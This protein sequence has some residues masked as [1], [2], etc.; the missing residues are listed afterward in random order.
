MRLTI[1]CIVSLSLNSEIRSAETSAVSSAPDNRPVFTVEASGMT[2]NLMPS[3]SGRL[4][5]TMPS[6]LPSLAGET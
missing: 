3:T 2:M 4:E 5:P 6:G 1:S